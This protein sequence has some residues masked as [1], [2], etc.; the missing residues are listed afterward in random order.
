VRQTPEFLTVME[1]NTQV[2]PFGILFMSKFWETTHCYL[3][4]ISV[5]VYNSYFLKKPLYRA[6]CSIL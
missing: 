4:Y 3:S 6:T 2:S 1:A 5:S